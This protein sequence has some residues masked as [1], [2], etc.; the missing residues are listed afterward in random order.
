[1]KKIR[2]DLWQTPLEKEGG[3][4]NCSYLLLKPEGNVLF[5]KAPDA[6]TFEQISKLGGIEYQVLSHRHEADPSP[7]VIRKTFG[8][9]LC[10]DVLESEEIKQTS[11]VDVVFGPTDEALDDIE[12]IHT[13][14][15]TQGG[16]S[17]LYKSPHGEVYL[18]S[19]DTMIPV[20]DQW[21]AQ[22]V[23][24]HGG[25]AALLTKSLLQMRDIKPDLVLSS[26]SVGERSVVD[27]EHGDWYRAVE[28][29]AER[30]P[31]GAI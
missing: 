30:P 23:P 31:I 18:F 11:Q 6:A 28:R 17:C 7:E 22:I 15:H 2:E 14:G 26:A 9:R 3:V 4:N 19:G 29:T 24:E 8:A 16:I 25:D 1:M 10:C 5:Y 21:I 12:I 20:N 27:V 13:P